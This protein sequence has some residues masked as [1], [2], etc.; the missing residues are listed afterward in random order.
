MA[1][2]LTAEQKGWIAH[3]IANGPRDQTNLDIATTFDTTEKTV[4][5]IRNSMDTR[6]SS[7]P[8]KIGPPPKITVEI[9]EAVEYILAY[10]PYLYQDEISD[11]IDECF[12]VRLH[13][14]TISKLL[15]RLE[16]TQKRLKV[17][18]AQRNQ[19]LRRNWHFDLMSYT[20][21]QFVFVNE[22]GSDERTG[23]RVYGYSRKGVPVTV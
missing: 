8:K 19:V 3:V 22:S 20:A 23:D 6:R 17:E 12:H 1:L 18:A 15:K 13:Q 7:E 21:D 10:H 2:R 9:K 14:T 5:N 11:F 4:R 16:I